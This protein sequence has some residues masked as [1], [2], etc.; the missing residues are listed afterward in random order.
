M[1]FAVDGCPDIKNISSATITRKNVEAMVKCNLTGETFY[2]SCSGT[3]WKGELGNCT[4][5]RVLDVLCL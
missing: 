2:L 1:V 4:K 3:T 5:G